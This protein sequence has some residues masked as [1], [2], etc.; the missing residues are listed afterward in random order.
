MKNKFTL[1]IAILFILV[2]CKEEPKYY[3][4][5]HGKIENAFTDSLI[6][7]KNGKI[8]IKLN[9]DGT[10]RD[11]IKAVLKGSGLLQTG[12]SYTSLYL[13]NGFDIEITQMLEILK[14]RLNSKV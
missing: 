14:I 7:H 2:A 3:A 8:V 13:K 4:V 12:K 1:I 9:E 11:T 10:F 6:Y 5:I